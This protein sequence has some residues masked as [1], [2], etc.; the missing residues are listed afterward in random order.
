M[1]TYSHSNSHRIWLCP[2][3]RQQCIFVSVLLCVLSCS[4]M[5]ETQLHSEDVQAIITGIATHP[6]THPGAMESVAQLLRTALNNSTPRDVDSAATSGASNDT[7]SQPQP[8]S[9]Q[10]ITSG[11]ILAMCLGITNSGCPTCPLCR[12][13]PRTG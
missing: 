8:G 11:N 9:Q 12:A 2:V 7:S 5:V 1:M 10:P 6:R 3:H 4:A 13:M